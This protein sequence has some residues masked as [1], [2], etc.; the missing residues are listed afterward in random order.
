MNVL[1]NMVELYNH[2]PLESTY[3]DVVKGILE[4]LEEAS[5]GTIYDIAELT[6]SSRT[7]VWRMVQKMGYPTF[8]DF[9][10]ALKQAVSKY[11]YYNRMLP[12]E[13]TISEDR[14]VSAFAAQTA[15]AKKIIDKQFSAA[16]FET[17]TSDFY[18]AEQIYFYFPYQNCGATSLQQNLAMTG[19]KTGLYCLIPDMLENNNVLDDK[20]IVF[21]DAIEHAEVLDMQ[22]VFESVR[23]MGARIFMFSN[24]K[25]RYREYVD[26]VLY[27]FDSPDLIGTNLIIN[28]MYLMT[29]SEI[30]RKKYIDDG[31]W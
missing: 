8:S 22:P 24:K 18:A 16:L 21:I 26:K 12:P 10:H 5:R 31:I 9:K 2:L 28:Q 7:T 1:Q 25:S 11:T 3:R 15:E 20:S 17:V 29:L 23:K 27:T 4:N 19:K 6:N 30:Y 13:L 14:I